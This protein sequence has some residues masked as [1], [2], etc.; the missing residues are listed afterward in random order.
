MTFRRIE[1]LEWARTRMGRARYDLAKSN[2][3][4]VT[5][6]EIG[7]ALD[8]VPLNAATDDG[9][10]EL[11]ETLARRYGLPR[12]QVLVTAGATMGIFLACAA[13]VEAGRPVLLETPNY[14]PLLRAAEQAGAAIRTFE[15]RFDRGWQ[16]DLPEL[17]RRLDPA[18]SAILMTNPHN[19]SGAAAS[20][21][22]MEAIGRLARDRG[23]TVV[24]SEVYLDNATVPGLKPAAC[25]GPNLVSIGSLSKVYGLGGLRIGWIAGPGEAMRKARAALDYVECD[26]AAPS[27]RIAAVAL[28]RAPELVERCRTIVARNL[29]VVREWIAARGDL[30]WTEPAGGTV[31]M[32]RLPE[33]V[34]AVALSECLR[35]DHSTLVVPGDF[36]GAPGFVRVSLGTDEEVLRGGLANVAVALDS[37]RTRRAR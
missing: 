5:R 28:R 15:R 4:A 13:L 6:E 2:I 16:I 31:C 19:P 35:T 26:L 20:A 14:E 34:D 18:P 3:K 24:C 12:S 25:C 22:T 27:E 30:A 8:D 37:M 21:G 29:A 1:Y 9:D 23:A 36:F 32:I 10:L 7:L 33:G 11:R 17:E